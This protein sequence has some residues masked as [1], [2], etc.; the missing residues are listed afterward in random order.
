M[1]Y[2]CIYYGLYIY[3]LG[4]NRIRIF[5]VVLG[6]WKINCHP[7]NCLRVEVVYSLFM[8]WMWALCLE[9]HWLLLV[10]FVH[11]SVRSFHNCSQIFLFFI[12]LGLLIGSF[13]LVLIVYRFIVFWQFVILILLFYCLCLFNFLNLFGFG[14]LMLLYWL[15]LILVL[16]YLLWLLILGIAFLLMRR[17]FKGFVKLFLLFLFVQY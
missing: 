14:F 13:V 8:I 6:R 4:I 10:L 3:L 12:F 7:R 1:V 5:L 9:C 16:V 2:I 15:H 17:C 11:L